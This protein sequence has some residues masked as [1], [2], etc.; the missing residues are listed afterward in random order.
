MAFTQ[1]NELIVCDGIKHTQTYRY[2][3]TTFAYT[4]A[5]RIYFD[6]SN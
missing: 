5:M 6:I 1:L 2:I 4:Y 3:S